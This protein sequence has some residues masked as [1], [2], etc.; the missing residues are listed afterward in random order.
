[1]EVWDRTKTRSKNTVIYGEPSEAQW[2]CPMKRSEE[3]TVTSLKI[4]VYN[5]DSLAKKMESA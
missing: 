5:I 1:M 4:Q 2:N 3:A